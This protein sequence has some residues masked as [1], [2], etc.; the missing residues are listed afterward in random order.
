MTERLR[1]MTTAGVCAAPARTDLLEFADMSPRRY[2]GE[3]IAAGLAQHVGMCLDA[4]IGRDRRP[5]DH[6]GEAG[7]R[8]APRS[9]TN[10]NGDCALSR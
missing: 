1:A 9:E 8:S 5:L 4:D 10:T 2:R 6:A 3:L 7:R